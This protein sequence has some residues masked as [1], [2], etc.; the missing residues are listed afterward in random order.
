MKINITKNGQ[1]LT[2]FATMD[3]ERHRQQASLP[4][5]TDHVIRNIMRLHL[6][7]HSRDQNGRKYLTRHGDKDWRSITPTAFM[8]RANHD[9]QLA[10]LNKKKFLD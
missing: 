2:Q 8:T 6:K 9:E 4:P 10:Q 1:E 7:R 5:A 3:G